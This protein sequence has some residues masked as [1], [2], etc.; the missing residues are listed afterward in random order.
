MGMPCEVPVPRNRI[1]IWQ[2]RRRMK[3]R[4]RKQSTNYS[5]DRATYDEKKG[6]PFGR[7]FAN[8]VLV[9]GAALVAAHAT[10]ATH[11]AHTRVTSRH[12]GFLLLR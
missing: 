4:C 8:V 5:G 1:S 10:H 9:A 3:V 11:T 7:P 6:R 2:K 12:G